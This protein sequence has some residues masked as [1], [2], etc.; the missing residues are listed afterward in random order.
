MITILTVDA[1]GKPCPQPVVM[2][3]AVVDQGASDLEVLVENEISAQNVTR[4]LQS[5]GF[6]VSSSGT[7]GNFTLSAQRQGTSPQNADK[8]AGAEAPAPQDGQ[9]GV[10]LLSRTMGH[11]SPE[12]G[13]ALI[14]AFL[15]TLATSPRLPAVVAL[16][17]GG[18][19]LALGDHSASETLREMESR[20]CQILVCGT[21]VKH[22]GFAE[23]VTVGTISNMF[24]I[25]E[26]LLRTH[27]QLTI[28]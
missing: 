23:K 19:F 16:M 4:F 12:L 21:C 22:F 24:E 20:G 2:A 9:V 13:E 27:R 8:P 6:L 11:E 5:Q 1:R 15:G 10:L 26:A 7:V 3:K 28:G 14:K 25:T 18:V 17:N